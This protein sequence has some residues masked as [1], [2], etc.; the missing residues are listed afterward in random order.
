[1]NKVALK[2]TYKSCKYSLK[3]RLNSLTGANGYL[4][5]CISLSSLLGVLMRI[6]RHAN[7]SIKLKTIIYSSQTKVIPNLLMQYLLIFD[8]LLFVTILGFF[9]SPV[10]SGFIYFFGID[11]NILFSDNKKFLRNI[12]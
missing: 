10:G 8:Y 7:A 11:T 1:M 9:F 2:C 4:L 5:L 12:F 3:L 6:I